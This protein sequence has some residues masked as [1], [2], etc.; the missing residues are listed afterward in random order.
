MVKRKEK[1]IM[2]KRTFGGTRLGSSENKTS[3][4]TDIYKLVLCIDFFVI[5]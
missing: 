4:T 3:S 1:D 5:P 2:N